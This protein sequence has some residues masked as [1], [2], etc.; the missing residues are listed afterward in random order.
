MNW[1]QRF[2]S[3]LEGHESASGLSSASPSNPARVSSPSTAAPST[4]D[5]RSEAETYLERVQE[6]I[7]RLGD[8]FARGAINRTQF[9]HLYELYQRERQS[10]ETILAISPE[11]W[12]TAKTEGQS[13]TIRRDHNALALGF[14]IYENASGIPLATL[15]SFDLDPSLMV[16][17]LSS[18]REAAQEMFGSRIR[19]TAIESG[20]WV[21]FIAG[22]YTTLIALYNNEPAGRQVQNLEETHLFFEQ[23]NRPRLTRTPIQSEGLVFPHEVYLHGR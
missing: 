18:Y 23:A 5:A 22:Q 8:E 15:G 1:L 13:I 7:N 20:R 11:K 14:S 17:M 4:G 3:S 9:I 6:K 16:P 21:C 2:L 12:Q 19:S 10:I